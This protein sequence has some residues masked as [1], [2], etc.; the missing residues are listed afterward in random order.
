MKVLVV[1]NAAWPA[2]GGIEVL[3]D[4]LLPALRDC[5]HEITLLTSALAQDHAEVSERHGITSHRTQLIAALMRREPGLLSRERQRVKRLLAELGP[6]L[7]HAHDIGPNLWAV[8]KAAPSAPIVTT[9][10]IGYQSMGMGTAE[11]AGALLR[12]CAWVTGVSATAVEEVLAVEPSL[13]GRTSVIDNGIEI[14]PPSG[15]PVVDG[16]ILCLGRLVPQ[17]GFE[18][19]L[20]ALALIADRRPVA[21]IVFAGDGSERPMLEALTAELGL[22]D[23]VMFLGAV[24]HADVAGLLADAHVVALPSRWEGQPIV[25]L[26]AGAAGRPLISS[27]VDGL[28]GV[29]DDGVTGVV[30]PPDDPAA[31]ASA[32]DRLLADHELCDRLGAAAREKI[33]ARFGM[34]RCVDAYDQLYRQLVVAAQ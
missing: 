33:G 22:G 17:K 13:V 11:S 14:P 29:V 4:R 9:M 1:S 30:V 28:A 23:R 32:L 8:V 26:E 20:H 34:A 10:H 18:A 31:L 24:G 21:H 6:D 16:R 27:A 15:R 5:G 7:I 2:V 12:S 3:L 19:V 25:A